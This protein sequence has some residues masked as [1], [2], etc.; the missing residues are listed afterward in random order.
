M[1]RPPRSQEQGGVKPCL[2]KALGSP[3]LVWRDDGASEP[4]RGWLAKWQG[5]FLGRQPERQTTIEPHH[6][7]SFGHL[8]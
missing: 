2:E 8:P 4:R 1:L 5:S 6:L 3:L 7:D